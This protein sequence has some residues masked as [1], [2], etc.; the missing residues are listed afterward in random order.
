MTKYYN[1]NNDNAPPFSL[2]PLPPPPHTLN[3]YSSKPNMVEEEELMGRGVNANGNG[4]RGYRAVA[5]PWRPWRYILT[6]K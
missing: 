5:T 1:I 6:Q 4:C 3:E 2:L